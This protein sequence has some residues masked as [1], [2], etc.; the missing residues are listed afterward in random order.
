MWKIIY[1]HNK[2]NKILGRIYIF[3]SRKTGLISYGITTWQNIVST[4]RYF[5]KN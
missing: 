5:R 1:P 3:H 2:T 4:F